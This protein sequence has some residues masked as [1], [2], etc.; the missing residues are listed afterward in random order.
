M[1]R[2]RNT[3]K[4]R[5]MNVVS[6]ALLEFSN[7]LQRPHWS[8]LIRCCRH[9][10]KNAGVTP[11]RLTVINIPE[12]PRDILFITPITTG[13]CRKIHNTRTRL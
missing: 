9:L 10:G 4:A 11:E 3:H 8:K 5:L 2:Q 12:F 7:I 6:A 13:S 1:P